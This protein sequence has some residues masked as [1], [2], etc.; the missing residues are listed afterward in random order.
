MVW[1]VECATLTP[2]QL[3]GLSDA[4]DGE[5]KALHTLPHEK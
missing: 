2:L 5:Q 3:E 1:M 4:L